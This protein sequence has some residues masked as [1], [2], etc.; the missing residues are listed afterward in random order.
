MCSLNYWRA[1]KALRSV[2][3]HLE[4]RKISWNESKTIII[5]VQ[6]PTPE[7]RQESWLIDPKCSTPSPVPPCRK[8]WD[9]AGFS[10]GWVGEKRYTRSRKSQET[11]HLPRKIETVGACIYSFFIPNKGLGDRVIKSRGTSSPV[12]RRPD[13]PSNLRASKTR[14]PRSL[15][16]EERVSGPENQSFFCCSRRWRWRR[17]WVVALLFFLIGSCSSCFWQGNSKHYFPIMRLRKTSTRLFSTHIR[18]FLS[19]ST[20]QCRQILH[21][22]WW[23]RSV[24][25]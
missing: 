4:N 14:Y 15:V 7:Q 24:M 20:T 9:L 11:I 18:I 25:G 21:T 5:V 8:K 6:P 17:G 1:T 13:C 23:V 2:T 16:N 19:N 22:A 3:W 10:R 12:V